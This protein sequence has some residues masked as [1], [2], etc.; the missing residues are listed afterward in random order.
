MFRALLVTIATD[1]PEVSA[2]RIASAVLRTPQIRAAC[3]VQRIAVSDLLAA[4]DGEK[5]GNFSRVLESIEKA[6]AQRGLEFGSRP[7]INSVAPRRINAITQ[8]A[9]LTIGRTK[10]DMTEMTPADILLAVVQSDTETAREFA[11]HGL[12]AATI[13]GSIP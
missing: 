4:V 10:A 13:Q 9:I 3:D 5:E 8:Q 2:R 12:T 1:E 11:Q 6:V 7:H